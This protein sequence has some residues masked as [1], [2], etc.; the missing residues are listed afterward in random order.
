MYRFEPAAYCGWGYRRIQGELLELA[1]RC[2]HGTFRNMEQRVPR[3]RKPMGAIVERGS[4]L[5][6]YRLGGVLHEYFRQA[7]RTPIAFVQR[8]TYG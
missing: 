2:F 3:P 7:A 4:V 1:C 5:R 6:R 8:H